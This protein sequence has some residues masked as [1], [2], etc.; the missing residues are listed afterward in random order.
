MPWTVRSRELLFQ[1]T[2]EIYRSS[3]I[4]S[5]E[6]SFL[7]IK[8]NSCETNFSAVPG[9]AVPKSPPSIMGRVISTSS[10]CST[11]GAT[12]VSGRDST[13]GIVAELRSPR[14]CDLRTTVKVVSARLTA[15]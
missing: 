3:A 5:L 8:K 7:I 13:A 10:G 12:S 11:S 9:L 15:P 1:G 14:T 4:R 2:N 6:H